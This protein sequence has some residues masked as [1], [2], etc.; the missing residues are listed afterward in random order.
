MNSGGRGPNTS[1]INQGIFNKNLGSGS[2]RKRRATVPGNAKSIA[3]PARLRY[4]LA[5]Q[6][7]GV[8]LMKAQIFFL[9]LGLAI[10]LGLGLGAILVL[11]PTVAIADCINCR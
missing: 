7:S 3:L 4:A 8:A 2:S 5:K 9:T 6:R 10:S 11:T 1:V